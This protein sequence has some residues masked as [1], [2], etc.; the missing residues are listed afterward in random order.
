MLTGRRCTAF[1]PSFVNLAESSL[2]RHSRKGCKVAE[3]VALLP[4]TVVVEWERRARALG[5]RKACANTAGVRGA[6][7]CTSFSGLHASCTFEV[8]PICQGAAYLLEGSGGLGLEGYAAAVLACWWAA[9]A[10]QNTERGSHAGPRCLETV[11]RA[12]NGQ[13]MRTALA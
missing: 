11:W 3:L 13:R 6:S 5:A 8:Q 1:C 2:A 12:R 9:C 4:S 10:A 7:L